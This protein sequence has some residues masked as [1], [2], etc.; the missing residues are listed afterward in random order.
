MKKE[1]LYSRLSET[2]DYYDSIVDNEPIRNRAW[3][4]RTF[5]GYDTNISVRSEFL[6]SDYDRFRPNSVV[7]TRP[8]EIIKIAM[9][10]YSKV[11]I[12]KN[13]IDIMSD[14]AVQG[15]RLQHPNPTVE[16]FY[17]KWFDK[18]NGRDRSERFLNYLYRLGNVV[19]NRVDAKIPS[20]KVKQWKAIGNF[21][22]DPTIKRE[23]PL[24]YY[25]LNPTTVDVIGEE[26]S[27]FTGKYVYYLK[28]DAKLKKAISELERVGEKIELPPE[29][30]EA[31]KSKTNKYILPSDKLYVAHYK[32]DDWQVWAEPMTY[33]IVD[34][35][36]AYEKMRLADLAALDGAISNIRLWTMGWVDTTNP[37]NSMIP[38]RS[39]LNKVRDILHNNTGG[40]SLDL[41]WGP[42]LTFKESNSQV[43]KFLGS[44]K[45]EVP[46]NAIYD[47]LGVPSVLRSGSKGAGGS[48]SFIALKTL[49]ERLEYGRS[50]LLDFWNSE[51]K[52]VQKAMGFD[53]PAQVMFDKLILSDESTELDLL[54]KLADRDLISSESLLEKFDMLPNV[55]KARIQREVKKRGKSMPEKASPFHN[56]LWQVKMKESLLMQGSIE[57]EDA[58][59]NVKNFK[60]VQP[61]GRPNN[62]V[63]TKKRKPKPIGKPQT[64]KA[65]M[66][67]AYAWVSEA[68]KNIV[69]IISPSILHALGKNNFRQL[70]NQESKEAEYI[71]FSVLFG[72]DVFEDINKDKIISLLDKDTVTK[73]AKNTFSLL[74]NAFVAQF[75]RQPNMEEMRQIYLNTYIIE[76]LGYNN[77]D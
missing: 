23:I 29:I 49:V 71:K 36:M 55:E 41:V 74:V 45:Y 18:V 7:P 64:G 47:G 6:Q 61:V 40:G 52:R 35:L 72:F 19:I 53:T 42:D 14:F 32:K 2:N 1:K 44:A 4:E 17:N 76:K 5:L 9:K 12:V 60:P 37:G 65:D 43:Y 30:V 56:P 57:P 51:I 58:G 46:L 15:I 38:S 26:L 24:R 11:G 39:A 13:V 3:A 63:E 27:T 69:N 8:H 34:D 54:M 75:E 59:L 21:N 25:F 68:Y 67:T 28:L 10:I 48:A 66:S 22:D 31:L 77:E 16:R 62:V 70:N 73:D 50:V 20:S 33:S